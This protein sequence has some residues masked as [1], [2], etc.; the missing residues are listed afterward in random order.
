MSCGSPIITTDTT[1]MPETC[2][3]AALYFQPGSKKQLSDHL[4]TYLSN[5]DTRKKFKGR[6][7][8][9]SNE[10]ENYA[11]VNRRTNSALH[12]LTL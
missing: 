6:S 9:K 8:R 1:A 4:L 12:A 7:L 3:D 2:G 10:Y 11:L 5:E